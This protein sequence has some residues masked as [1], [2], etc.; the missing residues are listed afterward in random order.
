MTSEAAKQVG[1][2]LPAVGNF[3]EIMC[4]TPEKRVHF[5]ALVW[6]DGVVQQITNTPREGVEFILREHLQRMEQDAIAKGPAQ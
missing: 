2:G 1:Q 6:T 5:V 4:G 3:I